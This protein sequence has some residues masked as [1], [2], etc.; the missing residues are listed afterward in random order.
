MS[1]F[2]GPEEARRRRE[3][4]GGV[5]FAALL[6][7]SRKVRKHHVEP[8]TPVR[9]AWPRQGVT[10]HVQRGDFVIPAH[11]FD[12]GREDDLARFFAQRI[13]DDATPGRRDRLAGGAVRL[14]WRIITVVAA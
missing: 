4:E 7:E 2:I 8:G 9:G 5:D 1:P 12:E 3:A 13:P 10:F 14:H 11:L 6:R